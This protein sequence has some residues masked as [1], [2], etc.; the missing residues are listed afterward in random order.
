MPVN[1]EIGFTSSVIR[2]PSRF[3][4]RAQLVQDCLKSL[5]TP[6]GL[7]A[8]YGKRGVGKSSLMRQLQAMAT[9]DFTLLKKAG[10]GHAIPSHPR[11]YLT[12]YYVC[13]S[14]IQNATDLLGRLCN[15]QNEEDGLLRLVPD[16]GK[17]LVEFERS[18]EVHAGTDL[19]VVA[20]GAKGVES[21][22]YAR[23][24][25][26][27]IVQ[28]FRNFVSSIVTH[29][30]KKRMRRDGLLILLDE[31]D[32]IR[33]KSSIGSLIKSLSSEEVKFAISG[34]GHDLTDLV[35]DHASVE[36]L[37]EE[38]ALEVHPMSLPEATEI[39][40]TAEKLFGG[41]IKFDPGVAAKIAAASQGYPYFVQLLGKECVSQANTLNTSFV[42]EEVYE[43]VLEDVR[44][45]K[46]FPTLESAY[47]RAIGNSPDRQ[48]LLH[49][50]AEQKEDVAHYN[51]D[52][53]RVVL[54]EARKTAEDFDVKYVDQLIPRL[55]DE[56]YGP[57]LRRLTERQGVYE[58]VNPVL[59]LYVNLRRI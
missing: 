24:V 19:K 53:G 39:V 7:I 35:V 16:D 3:V 31:F 38:G 59:R 36:R 37:L 48:V 23:V 50:L 29:Q 51:E 12:A 34:I 52:L 47:Q 49:L 2:D 58:F 9:G 54:K 28:T 8:V 44:S 14:T 10:L 1:P 56:A 15:D 26:N 42:S 6:L 25:P 11:S 33:D 55:V 5:D 20:W 17:E 27:D 41:A 22:R 18:K 32:V 43:R 21:S 46:A 45:G 30:V 13:D 40:T 4:G 57:V